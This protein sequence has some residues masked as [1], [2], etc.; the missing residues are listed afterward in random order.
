MTGEGKGTYGHKRSRDLTD[1]S[2]TMHSATAVG[3]IVLPESTD[4]AP[5]CRSGILWVHASRNMN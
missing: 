3:E 4:L 5:A 2:P 1:Y